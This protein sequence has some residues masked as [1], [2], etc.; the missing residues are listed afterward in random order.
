MPATNR[1]TLRLPDELADEL[2]L[3]V[4][5]GHVPSASAAVRA[6]LEV[7]LGDLGTGSQGSRRLTIRLPERLARDIERLQVEGEVPAWETFVHN[8]LTEQLA[9]TLKANALREK[10]VER[11]LQQRGA[12]KP[13]SYLSP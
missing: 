12:R 9:A 13:P 5:K 2:H 3:A 7:Y 1:L 8:A 10:Q 11:R 4:E 6:A